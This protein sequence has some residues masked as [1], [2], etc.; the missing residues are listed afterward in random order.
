MER[1]QKNEKA[2]KER[3]IHKE[4]KWTLRNKRTNK[5]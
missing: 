4:R 1:G 2:G 3:R 5:Y